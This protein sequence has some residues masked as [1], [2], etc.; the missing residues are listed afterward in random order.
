MHR[1]QLYKQSNKMH[2]LYVFILQFL[3][4]CTCFER[5]FRSSSRVHDLLYLQLCTTHDEMLKPLRLICM[6]F[7]HCVLLPFTFIF[8]QSGVRFFCLHV[9]LYQIAALRLYSISLVFLYLCYFF[10]LGTDKFDVVCTVHCN[11]LHITH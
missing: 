3:Y 11:Q 7:L 8:M 1:N 4:N 9:L 6:F 10:L 5:P 2:F